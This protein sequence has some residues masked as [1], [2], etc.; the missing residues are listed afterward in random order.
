MVLIAAKESIISVIGSAI[1]MFKALGFNPAEGEFGRKHSALVADFG[2][3]C[4][5]AL[6]EISY[7]WLEKL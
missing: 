5:W 4:V 3:V 6:L 7:P 2:R 1:G